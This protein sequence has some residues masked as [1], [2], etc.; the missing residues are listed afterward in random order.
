[1]WLFYLL[2]ISQLLSGQEDG[3][4][5]ATSNSLV[6]ARGGKD[7]AFLPLRPIVTCRA[8]RLG[9]RSVVLLSSPH[10]LWHSTRP[11]K[12]DEAPLSRPNTRGQHRPIPNQDWQTQPV[13][14]S[15]TCVS[16]DTHGTMTCWLGWRSQ[17]AYSCHQ[18]MCST[19]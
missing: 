16:P 1:M 17:P 6:L 18:L 8:D 2:E 4:E 5:C 15:C 3:A 13:C 14:G 12:L 11:S 9:I 19:T 10:P 7:Q